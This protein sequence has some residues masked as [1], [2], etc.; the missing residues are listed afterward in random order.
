MDEKILL[1]YD[2]LHNFF[3]P[4]YWWPMDTTY[5]TTNGSD[6]RFEIVIGAILTQN[7]AWSNVE[8]ALDNLKK[9]QKLEL[10]T[11]NNEDITSLKKLIKPSGFFNQKSQRLKDICRF[12]LETYK[13]NLDQ[14]FSQPTRQ[15]RSELLQLNGIGP[16]T[17]DSIL[18]YAGSKPIFV[19]DAY[20][21]R[22]CS[23]IPLSVDASSY[24]LIQSYFQDTLEQQYPQ[25]QLP[26]IYNEY[27]AFIVE[28]GKQFC[29]KQTP[30][31]PSCPL[32]NICNFS[33]QSK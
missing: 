5:H 3:G 12:L 31:C 25:H 13:G 17:A 1:I 22:M 2:H 28:L 30:L 19:V 16:E 6:P 11:M 18:L 24:D 23:R 14:M 32:K 9:E 27:H 33:K 4:Q 26:S 8:K 20:T 29:K 10:Q 21:K 15:L 7:T